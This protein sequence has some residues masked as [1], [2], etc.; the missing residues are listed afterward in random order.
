MFRSLGIP[1]L[2]TKLR[3]LGLF[4]E[5][6]GG[7]DVNTY[8][9]LTIGGGICPAYFV[10]HF[11]VRNLILNDAS[12][13]SRLIAEALWR[14]DRYDDN[15]I[16]AACT[17]IEPIEGAAASHS[18]SRAAFD[19]DALKWIDG[20]CVANQEFPLLLIALAAVIT[21]GATLYSGFFSS[22]AT[23]TMT[24]ESLAVDVA[25]K[26]VRLRERQVQADAIVITGFDYL[27][28]PVEVQRLEGC[29]VYLDPAW[30]T[31]HGKKSSS[32]VRTYGFWAST[33]MSILRQEP[34]RW[35]P[36]YEIGLIEFYTGMA[37][38]IRI[39]SERNTVLVAYQTKPD[40]VEVVKKMIFRDLPT[41]E[42]SMEKTSGTHLHEYLFRVRP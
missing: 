30:P 14:E 41:E 23:R 22:R 11:G 25:K 1:Y 18:R 19:R 10:E 37:E 33:V 40:R 28:I 7:T 38:T 20:F 16:L 27:A 17:G 13:F 26:A 31:Q 21:E 15:E 24:P 35:P 2:G 32:N 42:A 34:R 36:Q 12:E 4:D 3:F 5:L 29:V 9:D 39:L 6:L 8:A